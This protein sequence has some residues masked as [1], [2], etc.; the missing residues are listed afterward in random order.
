MTLTFRTLF[1]ALTVLFTMAFSDT[2][3]GDEINVWLGTSSSPLSKGIYFSTLN[4]EN[5]QLSPATLAAE[6]TGPGFLAL[7]PKQ[8]VLYAVGSLNGK[9]SVVAYEV[10][11]QDGARPA[12]QLMNAVEVGDGGA[13]HLAVDRSAQLLL[14]AQYGGG[15]TAA[16][17]LN[18]DGSIRERTQ[19]LKH[20]GGSGVVEGRQDSPHA[21]WVGFSPD[22]RFAFVP[23]LGLDQVLIYRVDVAKATI[24]PH[25]AG[26]CPP[27]SGPRH[28][29]FHPNKKWIYVVNELDLTVSVFDYDA[30]A[31]AMKLK[32]TIEAVPKAELAAE[33]F[34]SGSE[35]RVHPSGRFVYSA[36]RGHDTITAFEVDGATGEL[37]VLQRVPIRG[38]TPRNFNL[39]PS[40]RWL[41]AAGQDSHTLSS[42]TVDADTGRLTYHRSIIHV[43]SPIC[44]LFAGE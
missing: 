8:S 41:L 18:Q 36:N 34:T 6:I 44:V 16:F 3:K 19:L 13:T 29:K 39:D 7:N 15:S 24:E 31:G 2:T 14:T 22:E 5:G 25:G 26:V 11:Q 9:P 40:G 27:G 42:F 21:H 35:I 20:R 38:A 30:E 43:P 28:M 33:E 10:Q 1:L 37:T 17:A 32:Q 12:L 4:T 23:D